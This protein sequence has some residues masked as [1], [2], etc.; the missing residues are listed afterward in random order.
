MT[1]DVQPSRRGYSLPYHAI[2]E[3]SDPDAENAA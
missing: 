2:M 3:T 1:D